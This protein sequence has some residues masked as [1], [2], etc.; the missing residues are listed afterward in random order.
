MAEKAPVIRNWRMPL[1]GKY[2]YGPLFGVKDA[3]HPNGHR[4]TD[5]NGFKEG[6]P[7]LAVADGTIVL[8]K[9]SDVLGNVVVLQVGGR[10]FGYC[11]LSKPSPRKVGTVVA[12]GDVIG[13]AG[14][15]GSA[16]SGT[17][18]HLT[19][20]SD[21]NSVFG[22]KVFDADAFLKEKIAAEK[23]LKKELGL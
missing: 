20:G 21:A 5:Y 16:S 19:L 17:H 8:N 22:G 4:G 9:W 6:T 12:S 18:L 1:N 3:W 14:T 23:A 10:F 2:S 13:A 15:S 11:H 7:L